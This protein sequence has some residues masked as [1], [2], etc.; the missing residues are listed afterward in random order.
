VTTEPNQSPNAN[1]SA[2]KQPRAHE[3]E[4][5]RGARQAL[6]TSDTTPVTARLIHEQSTASPH[7]TPSN[8]DPTKAAASADEDPLGALGRSKLGI[9]VMVFVAAGI[10]GLPLI[11]YSRK[12]SRAEK[13]FWTVVVLLYT[14]F[15][16]YLLY[17]FLI[18][19]A[20]RLNNFSW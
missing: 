6:E 15:V 14:I 11:L 1:P 5:L 9:L 20:G 19:L 17:L 10:M 16:F 2:A 4:R 13:V 7:E 12:F 18:W 8:I 3:S